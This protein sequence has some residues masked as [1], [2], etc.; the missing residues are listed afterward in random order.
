MARASEHSA[1]QP[2][3]EGLVCVGIALATALAIVGIFAFIVFT[4]FG[5]SADFIYNQ[6]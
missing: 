1:K 5:S 4:D 2:L 6:F 3:N